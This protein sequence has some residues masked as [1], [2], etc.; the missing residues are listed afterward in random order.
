VI[1]WLICDDMLFDLED[2]CGIGGNPLHLSREAMARTPRADAGSR[3][4]EL[5]S[6]E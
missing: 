5:V 6:D 4:I 1:R 3:V 2:D